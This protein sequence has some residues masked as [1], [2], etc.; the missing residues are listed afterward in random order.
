MSS[1][2]W[3][4]QVTWYLWLSAL[5]LSIGFEHWTVSSAPCC[6]VSVVCA[7]WC[8]GELSVII[9]FSHVENTGELQCIL[10]VALIY[11]SFFSPTARHQLKLHNCGHRAVV[12]H[13]FWY[14]LSLLVSRVSADFWWQ[15][16]MC[17][18]D[19]AKGLAGLMSEYTHDL[20]S[21]DSDDD[22]D[23]SMYNVETG[24]DATRLRCSDYTLQQNNM[25]CLT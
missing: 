1:W 17:V 22:V 3:W 20:E 9:L 8:L 10:L 5:C 11:N 13:Q 6:S 24:Y 12:S 4:L 2:Q 7:W 16:F 21:D 23:T 15:S 25:S 18:S 14:C 19:V